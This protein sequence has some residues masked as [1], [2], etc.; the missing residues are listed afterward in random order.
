M[1]EDQRLNELLTRTREPLM[2]SL[3]LRLAEQNGML[4]TPTIS[5]VTDFA[6]WQIGPNGTFRPGP[7]TLAALPSGA[8]TVAHDG[9]G[10]YLEHM[11]IM[12]DSLVELPETANVRVLNGIRKFWASKERYVRHGLVYK[13]GVLLWGPAGSG[14][15]VTAQLLM[16]EVVDVHDGIVIVC[17]NPQLC[18]LALKCIRAIEPTRPLIV[19]LEDIDEVIRQGAEHIVL[20]MLDGEHQTDNVVYVATTNHPEH[21]GARILNRP[22]RFDERI[23]VG[24]PSPLVRRTYLL[25]ATA[26]A[27]LSEAEIDRWCEDTEGLSIAHLRELV[28]AVHCLDQ[29]YDVVLNRLRDLAIRPDQDNGFASRRVGEFTAVGNLQQLHAM[30]MH[31][32]PTL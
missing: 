25:K 3:Q 31:K 22:S 19:V 18:V 28:V 26:A 15:T 27:S 8:Y 9:L 4:A 29:E 1:N 11:K 30:Q 24:M 23:F 13:R 20:A 32:P 10:P 12:T 5:P 21:L 16:K 14:K 17:T 6:Q 7:P 2:G